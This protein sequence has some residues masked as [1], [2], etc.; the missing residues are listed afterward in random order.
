MVNSQTV[1]CDG[2]KKLHK[3]SFGFRYNEYMTRNGF[4]AEERAPVMFIEDPNVAYVALRYRQ[5]HD[6]MHTLLALPPTI[7][8]EL[9]LKM[10]E[11]SHFGL[12]PCLLASTLGVP[13]I[14]ATYGTKR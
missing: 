1:D 13:L 7:V 14:E 3:N 2:L 8:G 12:Y 5:I 11:Y 4:K 9:T 10:F 6:S